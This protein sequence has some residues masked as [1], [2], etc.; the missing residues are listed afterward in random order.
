[1]AV[2][3][4]RIGQAEVADR[5]SSVPSVDMVV[6]GNVGDVLQSADNETMELAIMVVLWQRPL[7]LAFVLLVDDVI[8]P[9]ELELLDEQ[10][11]VEMVV[12][13]ELESHTFDAEQLE[14]VAR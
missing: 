11:L 2:F 13:D 9:V 8:D 3:E 4:L 12:V 14:H 10:L 1:M 6:P 5:Y 7:I